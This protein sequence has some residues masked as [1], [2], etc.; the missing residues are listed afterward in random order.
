MEH[1]NILLDEQPLIVLPKL[2]TFL[3]LNEAIVLQQLN[4]WLRKSTNV[5]EERAWAYNSIGNWHKQF[6]FWSFETVKRTI[7]RLVDLEIVIKGNFNRS[8]LD[9]TLWYAI[10]YEKLNVILRE[11]GGLNEKNDIGS[12]C[13]NGGSNCTDDRLGQ[14]DPMLDRV[15]LTRPIPEITT[16]TTI[17]DT[18]KESKKEG[19]LLAFSVLVERYTQNLKL[20]DTIFEFIRMRV[21]IK[22][23]PTNRALEIIFETLN[24]LASSDEMKI[25]IL[26]RSIVNNWQDVFALKVPEGSLK[27]QPKKT[28]SPLEQL[29]DFLKEEKD[30]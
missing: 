27:P 30:G 24:K 11:K 16:E 26:N 14:I 28:G 18:N 25:E 15:N 17:S 6:P 1:S 22:K 5:R 9:K 8:S 4:Y 10:D 29:A 7:R 12:I 2:A 21:H 23:T 20:R 3:G 13:S 19:S